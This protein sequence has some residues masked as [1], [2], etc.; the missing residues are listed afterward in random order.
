MRNKRALV[1]APRVPEFD[2][3][4]GSRRVFHLIEF[5]QEAGWA[6]C[7]IAQNGAGSERYVQLLQQRGV[8][9]S[10]GFGSHTDQLI[11]ARRFDAAIFAFWHLAEK[12]IPAVRRFSPDTRV[13]VDM[14]DLH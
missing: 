11:A 5:L 14:I 8:E 7:F 13:I 10:I 6:V 2:R 3:E 9:T 4:S 12:H 1:C